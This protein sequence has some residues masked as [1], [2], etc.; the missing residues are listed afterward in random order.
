M[1]S[2]HADCYQRIEGANVVGVFSRNRERAEAAAKICGAQAVVD[3]FAL[4]DDSS[5]DAID[6]CLPSANHEEFVLAALQRGKHV[7]C[8]TPFAL[9]LTAAEAML[10]AAKASGRL[11]MVGLLERSIVQYEHI[12]RAVIAGQL[13]RILTITTYRLGSYLQSEESRRH[14]AD[15]T[16]ELMT[17]DYDFIRWLIGTPASVC[18]ASVDTESGIPGEVSAVLKWDSGSTATVTGSGIMPNGFPFSVGFR[19]L[20][21]KGAFELETV[22]EGAGPPKNTFRFYPETETVETLAIEEHDPYE[23]ELRYFVDA[24]HGETNPGLLDA[25]HAYEALKLSFATLQSVKESRVIRLTAN[26]R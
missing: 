1:G 5:I 9:E 19:I 23:R 14:Y 22:F 21:E 24:V 2:V 12:Q 3:A 16:L 4:L 8:E 20:F 13:G 11:F 7:F 15:P 18:A 25:R 26:P 6:V 17:L 10:A